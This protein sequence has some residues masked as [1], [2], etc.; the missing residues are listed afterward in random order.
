MTAT[1]RATVQ[2]GF[3]FRSRPKD[4]DFQVL[5]AGSIFILTPI[6]EAADSWV[7]EKVS[8]TEETQYFGQKGIVIEHRYVCDIIDGI[9]SDGLSLEAAA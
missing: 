5:N 2:D 9:L 4:V 7:E 8:I 1:P 3:K 6:T